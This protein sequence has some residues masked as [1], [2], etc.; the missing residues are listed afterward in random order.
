MGSQTLWQRQAE[1]AQE[2]LLSLVGSHHA[3]ESDLRPAFH[4]EDD[5]NTLDALE[6][7]EAR[8]WT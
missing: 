3:A 8:S 2:C 7:F 4:R 6:F 5:V 1:P